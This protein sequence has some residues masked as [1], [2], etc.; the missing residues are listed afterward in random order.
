[1]SGL[2]RV[3]LMRHAP[4]V[5]NE[6]GLVQG[7]EDWPLSASGRELAYRARG[8]FSGVHVS[9]VVSSP[10]NRAFRT[11]SIVFG[12]VD[13]ADSGWVEQAVPGLAGLRV[14]DA[15]RLFPGLV[16]ADGW[17]LP[18]APVCPEAESMRAVSSRVASALAAAVGAP[19]SGAVAVV[20]HG[21]P[22]AAVLA[23]AG[24]P[25]V[26]PANLWAY[27]LLVSEDGWEVVG[28][29][30]PVALTV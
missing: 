25:G 29:H 16:D 21:S 17:P 22:V 18:S 3:F 14:A 13:E 6:R 28:E 10:L 8:F 9:H 12:R 5:A 7:F 23:A 27:E 4:S 2:R 24:R 30:D 15:H 20:S 26:R 1:M 19:G 11:A